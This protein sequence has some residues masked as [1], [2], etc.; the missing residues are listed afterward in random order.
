MTGA[1]FRVRIGRARGTRIS[2]AASRL[3]GGD[4]KVF[5]RNEARG[6]ETSLPQ[7]VRERFQT[8][9]PR[10]RLTFDHVAEEIGRAWG[11]LYAHHAGACSHMQSS[12][13]ATSRL[14]KTS[15]SLH[16][17]LRPRPVR[18]RMNG[19]ALASRSLSPSM[20]RIP[21]RE[22]LMCGDV[23]QLPDLTDLLQRHS[24]QRAAIL[25]PET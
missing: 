7:P 1:P 24:R 8:K 4:Q 18:L 12:R 23:N 13:R 19:H 10:R 15:G 25:R 11:R 21:F 17:Q 6:L 16:M 14:S 2:R 20:L 5:I 22:M 9:P 3:P